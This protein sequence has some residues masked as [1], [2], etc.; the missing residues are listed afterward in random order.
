MSAIA[1]AMRI[2][3][4]SAGDPIA[5]LASA[6]RPLSLLLVID[7]AEHVIDR[8]RKIADA[9]I[10][11]TSGVRLLL[12]SQLPLKA[13]HE[14]AYRLGALEF[15]D[16]PLGAQQALDYGAV[17]LFADRAAAVDRRF[18]LSDDNVAAVIDICRRLDGVALGIELAAARVPLLGAQG[19]AQHLDQRFRLLV[20]RDRLAPSRQQTLLAA[21]EWSHGL[22]SQQQQTVFRRLGVFA[23]GFSL[24]LARAVVTDDELDEWTVIDLLGDLI[25]RSLLAATS[26]DAPRY[27]LLET[28]RVYALER[29]T[30]A[31]ESDAMRMRHANAVRAEFERAFEDYWVTSDAAYREKYEPELDNLRA[32]F[33]WSLEHDRAGAVALASTSDRLLLLLSLL[34][35]ARQYSDAAFGLIEAEQPPPSVAAR[36]WCSRAAVFADRPD[37][38]SRAAAQ[39]ALA[40]YR[41]LLDARGTYLCLHYLAYS[42]RN[43][44]SDASASLAEMRQLENPSWPPRL[45][46]FR[47]AIES[48]IAVNTGRK[49]EA[50][51][52]LE[53][54][55]RLAVATGADD[56]VAACLGSLAAI[57][58]S[59]GDVA[60]AIAMGR[61]LVDRCR[62]QR[63]MRRL[64]IALSILLNALLAG[65]SASDARQ[66]AE[67]FVAV[68][69]RLGWSYLHRAADAL[70]L[71]A[72]IEGR[73]TAA[74]RIAGF[75]DSAYA[76]QTNYRKREWGL[77]ASRSRIWLMLQ[78]ALEP[79]V[80]T[81]L[82][83][84]GGNLSADQ[85]CAIALQ[86]QADAAPVD[87]RVN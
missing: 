58:L 28:G 60:G 7:N 21:F 68:D 78:Q 38:L 17:A 32:A 86:M 62:Q 83:A 56:M 74:A 49:T 47:M 52:L 69:R 64:S 13:A 26:G 65:D 55:M 18:A 82:M 59:T 1:T 43:S 57:L 76:A 37:R 29:L 19:V 27:Y 81:T 4:G 34:V 16:A 39:L 35:E 33:G 10:E 31:S 36:F 71:L 9:V 48:T 77:E 41:E 73:T 67:E 40:I 30:A 84:E 70:A 79:G 63:N 50:R 3:L 42:Y 85:V 61:E 80:L 6:L 54:E 20:S 44:K 46:L 75:S 12:T 87:G 66:V 24:E 5:A 51:T 8:V 45:R 11:E 72:G 22:L 14:R 53:E 25:D 2:P 15:P 23:G